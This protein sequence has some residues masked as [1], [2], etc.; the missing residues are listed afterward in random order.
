[1]TFVSRKS[2]ALATYSP[3]L[4]IHVC[5]GVPP[6]RG[7]STLPRRATVCDASLTG[8]R[9]WHR[10]VSSSEIQTFV[11]ARLN[12]SRPSELRRAPV[13]MDRAHVRGGVRA[14]DPE[15]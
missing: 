11:A 9:P 15:R 10:V 4:G 6:V 3:D 8:K 14:I 2:A 7:T 1:V 12:P 5:V 13:A